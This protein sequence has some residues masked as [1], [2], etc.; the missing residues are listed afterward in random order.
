MFRISVS[1]TSL[2]STVTPRYRSAEHG[3]WEPLSLLSP[4]G[5]IWKVKKWS[6]PNTSICTSCCKLSALFISF[7][8]NFPYALLLLL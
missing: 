2:S 1:I 7:A 4:M 8:V 3:G 6:S 5:P